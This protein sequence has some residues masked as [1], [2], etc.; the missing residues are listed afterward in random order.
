MSFLSLTSI[1]RILHKSLFLWGMLLFIYSLLNNIP[2]RTNSV[3][4]TNIHFLPVNLT[5]K[6]LNYG[7]WLVLLIL[8]YVPTL[9]K[10][11]DHVWRQ[12]WLLATV[13]NGGFFVNKWQL[14]LKR[15]NVLYSQNVL[16]RKDIKCAAL[17]PRW[18]GSPRPRGLRGARRCRRPRPCWAARGSPPR[19]RSPP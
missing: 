4:N 3:L 6:Q 5:T 15:N 1:L 2:H 8:Y 18:P 13:R 12:A 17:A 16:L 11:Y 19:C 14:K 10:K 9:F 7:L